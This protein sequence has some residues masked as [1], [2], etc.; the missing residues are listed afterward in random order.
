MRLVYHDVMQAVF[1]ACSFPHLLKALWVPRD[2]RELVRGEAELPSC[3]RRPATA[4]RRQ[5][6]AETVHRG[7]ARVQ[8][9][10][11]EGRCELKAAAV[12]AGPLAGGC[13]FMTQTGG[14]C[15]R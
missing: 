14:A 4:Q 15:A 13:W 10:A 5:A 1:S 8:P 6:A 11:L 3:R 12:I 7:V 9:P 2:V